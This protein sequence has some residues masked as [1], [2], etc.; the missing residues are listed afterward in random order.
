MQVLA[1]SPRRMRSAKAVIAAFFATESTVQIELRTALDPNAS[2]KPWMRTGGFAS[3]GP[4]GPENVHDGASAGVP[5]M[6]MSGTTSTGSE[7]PSAAPTTT[8]GAGKL[9]RNAWDRT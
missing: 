2:R 5:G 3:L 7:S 9:E 1:P 8:L 6:L 4:D